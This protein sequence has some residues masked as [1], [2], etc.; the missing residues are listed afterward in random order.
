MSN[1]AEDDW[2]PECDECGCG[3]LGKYTTYCDSCLHK[4]LEEARKEAE[5]IKIKEPKTIPEGRFIVFPE[6]YF[7]AFIYSL[8]EINGS[9]LKPE[10]IEDLK[11]AMF[12]G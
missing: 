9:E 8:I 6:K 12:K 11:K 2:Y 4:I 5:K 1:Q 3:H 7:N 10:T